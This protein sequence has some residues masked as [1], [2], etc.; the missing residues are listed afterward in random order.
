LSASEIEI[1][2]D[3]YFDASDKVRVLIGGILLFTIYR[4]NI[5]SHIALSFRRS[6]VMNSNAALK[7]SIHQ[8]KG[9]SAYEASSAAQV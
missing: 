9:E 1:V 4:D 5:L 2:L 6:T 8:V 3:N 7:P